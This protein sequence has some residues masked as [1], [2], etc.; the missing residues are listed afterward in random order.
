MMGLS[1]GPVGRWT[2]SEANLLRSAM[3][4]SLRSFAAHLGVSFGTVTLWNR[5]G[6]TIE[7]TPELQAVLDTALAQAPPEARQRFED[8]LREN[9]PSVPDLVAAPVMAAPRMD[10][11]LLTVQVGGQLVTLPL[12][13]VATAARAFAAGQVGSSG[14]ALVRRWPMVTTI[15]QGDD[16][17][18]ELFVRG[19]GLL[20][21]NDRGQIEAAQALLQQAVDRDP[22]F[23]RAIAARGYTSW[24]Q[25]FAGWSGRSQALQDALRDVEAALAVDPE[26]IG[27]Q[28]T[29][30]RACWDMGWHERALQAGRAVYDLRPDSLD[31][32]VAFAR[33]LNNAGLAHYALPLL[34]RVLSVDPTH[35]A[36]VKL[37]VWCKVMVD[38]HAGA[39]ETARDHLLRTPSDAN[40][41]WAVALAQAAMGQADAAATARRGLEADPGDVTLWVLLGYLHRGAGQD[42]EALGAWAEGLEHVGE[43]V[44]QRTLV[45]RANLLAALDQGDEALRCAQVLVGTDPHNGYLRYRAA[46]VLAELGEHGDAVAM[47]ET[48][49]REGFRSAQLLRQETR[50]GLAPLMRAPGFGAALAGLD[51]E[52][53]RCA[54]LHTADLPSVQVARDIEGDEKR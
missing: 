43:S 15:E 13:S 24:R 23:A 11:V 37:S 30:I 6:A 32:C 38:D 53:A 41:R 14:P 25:Y 4:L 39:V 9:G 46:H 48:A 51:R 29:F 18:Y 1:M 7:P 10:E 35:P 22:R 45:W 52:V 8:A 27:A 34:E 31:A 28:T 17:A 19:Y 26:S 33:S 20:G 3:R 36:A 5:R 50:L 47:I 21:S 12:D 42:A 16:R 54:S 40:T 44:N 2:G 49:V